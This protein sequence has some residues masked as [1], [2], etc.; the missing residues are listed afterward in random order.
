MRFT[1]LLSSLCLFVG[2]AFAQDAAP[3]AHT[4]NPAVMSDAY[5]ALW[6]ADVQKQIDERIE[7]YRKA[8]ADVTLENVKPGTDVKVEQISHEFIFGAHIFNFRQLGS[9]ECNERYENLYGTLF[10]SATV[11]FYWQRFEFEKDHPRF[12]TEARDL[13]SF[14]NNCPNPKEQP[15]WRRPSSDQCVDFCKA[16]GIRVHGHPMVWGNRTWQH[17]KWMW[18]E[19]AT[20]ADKAALDIPRA[21]LYKKSTDE[22]YASASHYFDEYES[23]MFNRVQILAEHYGD[24]IDS[25]D[26]VNESSVDFHGNVQTGEKMMKSVYGV[27]P[28]D[29]PFKAFQTAQ[30]YLPKCVKLNINDY[31]NNQ[32]YVDQTRA[33]IE[34]GCKIDIVG[35]QMHLFNPKQT[36]EIAEGKAIP[37]AGVTMTPEGIWTTMERLS[38][39]NL[40]IHLSEITITAPNDDAVGRDIQAI[41]ARN[42]YRMWFSV[43]NMMGITWWNV[44]DDCGAPGEPTTSGIMTRDLQPKPSFYALD[45]LINHEWKTNFTQKAENSNV[46]LKFR[47]F[48]GKY[49]ITWTDASGTVQT[50]EIVVTDK[51]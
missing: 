43:P 23:R 16:K 38:Q 28:G 35:S 18:D 20:D 36:L 17:P 4:P 25:W 10:N 9:D 32:N 34:A 6:N 24:R 44:V 47:G 42:F 22:I 50:Q 51:K 49:R 12:A 41:V 8:D 37:F 19:V 39:N 21:D 48:K 27:M 13:P 31:A 40:P 2:A 26:V 5:Y 7:K 30:K 11:S 15:H 29:Y 45:Q 46:E 14:W 33:L 1:V 3:A